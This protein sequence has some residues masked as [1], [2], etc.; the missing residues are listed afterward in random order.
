M[1]VFRRLSNLSILVKGLTMLNIDASK[2]GAGTP[3]KGALVSFPI[4]IYVHFF[5]WEIDHDIYAKESE[6]MFLFPFV[7][8]CYFKDIFFIC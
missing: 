4:S 5:L 6:D 7:F 1:T 2:D 3:Q 8:G